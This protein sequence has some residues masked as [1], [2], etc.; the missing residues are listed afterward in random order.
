MKAGVRTR[1]FATVFSLILVVIGITGFFLSDLLRDNLFSRIENELKRHAAS[2]RAT[3]EIAPHLSDIETGDPLADKLGKAISA[4]VTVILKNGRVIGDSELNPLEIAAAENHG[5]RAEVKQALSTGK[6]SSRRFSTTVSH[7]MLYVAE[8]FS[9]PDSNGVVRV[10]KPL[11]EI[12]EAIGTLRKLLVIS[13]V[14]GLVIALLVA[15]ISSHLLSRTLQSLVDYAKQTADG[16]K[17]DPIKL[18][19]TGAFGGLAGSL[20]TLSDQLERH[21]S[22][23]AHQRD[24]FEA[25]LEGMSEAVIALDEQ[26]RVTLINSAGIMLLGLSGRPIGQMLLETIQVPSLNDVVSSVAP[27]KDKTMEFDLPG[28]KE[29]RI[30]ARVTRTRTGG[31]VVVL[32]DVTELRRL[33]NLRKDFVSNVSHELR[34]P[35]SIIQANA[36]TLLNGA[37]DDR[38]A[39]MDFLRSMVSNSERLSNLIGDLLDISRIEAGQYQLDLKPVPV[40]LSIWRAS[41]G[42]ETQATEKNFSIQVEATGD[43]NVLADPKAL[44]QVLFNLLDNAV[45]YAKPGGS[46]VIRAREDVDR[47]CIEIE[48]DGPGIAPK[49]RERLFERFYRVDPGRS[50][51]MGGTGLGLAI[52]KHLLQAMN[53][54]VGMTPAK[55]QGSI[56][57]VHLPKHTTAAKK[58]AV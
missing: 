21:V 7:D 37:I 28:E 14:I 50:R 46:V 22:D 58:P 30:L 10:S 51:K 33:E 13:G 17:P 40:A 3:I 48:D 31:V 38:E 26:E 52:V 5:N 55:P 35:V 19:S 53:G 45:K 12:S 11:S 54:E 20:N 32:M 6:G 4:R 39:A 36:E 49:N 18:T 57:K 34:T 42:L 56:F 1:L 44:D 41:A 24:Q 2:A 8:K 27:G 23:L 29:R 43:L 16:E 9:R 15:G 47:V 25:V